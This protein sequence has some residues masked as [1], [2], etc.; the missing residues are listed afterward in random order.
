M[1]TTNTQKLT[2]WF[3]VIFLLL[4]TS[5]TTVLFVAPK[6]VD[7]TES[8]VEECY[9][10]RKGTQGNWIIHY[11]DIKGLDYEPGFSYKIK[12]KRESD[13]SGLPGSFDFR[14]LE[15]LEKRDVT[16]D[17]VPEDLEGKEWKL[18]FLRKDGIQYGIEE[19]I[20]TIR[21]EEEGRVT[22]FGG[23]NNYFGNYTLDGRT[24]RFSDLGST[25]ML[26]QNTA[27][28]EDAFM[29]ILGLE[30]R[31]LFNQRKLILSA[32]GGNQLIFGYQ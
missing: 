20:P 26:C 24:L 2:R 29:Q 12:V 27:D 19:E 23:C 21:F 6:K 11:S 8:G 1:K 5:C 15:I 25:K 13:R 22:G 9:L 32:D 17:M 31:G 3:A 4:S 30:L 16:D 10:I 28:L 18:E 7:C 14:L